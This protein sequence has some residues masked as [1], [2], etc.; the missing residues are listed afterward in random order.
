M[1]P[2]RLHPPT[3]PAI[4]SRSV[5][6]KT[7]L[8][9]IHTSVSSAQV[10]CENGWKQKRM[11]FCLPW[12][13][14]GLS[15]EGFGCISER[16][17]AEA[18]RNK[19]G[20]HCGKGCPEAWIHCPGCTPREYSLVGWKFLHPCATSPFLPWLLGWNTAW[21]RMGRHS[22]PHWCFLY[23]HDASAFLALG[24]GSAE[25]GLE[26]SRGWDVWAAW[27]ALG[28]LLSLHI[29]ARRSWWGMGRQENAALGGSGCDGWGSAVAACNTLLFIHLTPYALGKI[30]VI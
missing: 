20:S 12:E 13:A 6:G 7:L 23:S 10:H 28:V 30:A 1:P 11:S 25:L 19:T 8:G 21:R 5:L 4:F 27:G 29:P 15:G 17:L 14:A 18:V 3:T 2:L 24:S 22:H 9:L 16:S 26:Q